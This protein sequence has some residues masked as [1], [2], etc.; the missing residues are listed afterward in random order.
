VLPARSFELNRQL[1]QLAGVTPDSSLYGLWYGLV[2]A[3]EGILILVV[4]LLAARLARFV[5]K[6]LAGDVRMDLQLV[7]LA[8]RLV[9][10]AVIALGVLGFLYV[11]APGMLTPVLGAVGLLGLAFGLAFQDVLKNFLSGV[12][13]L[14]ERPFRIGDVIQVGDLKGTVETIL[15]RVTVLK[16]AEGLQVL[17]PNQQVYTSAIVNST[18]YP[19]R[20]YTASARVAD[21]QLA[22]RLVDKVA[23]R[24]AEVKGVAEDPPPDVS[25]VPH[26]EWGATLEARFWVDYRSHDPARV[27]REVNAVLVDLAAPKSR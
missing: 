10:L 11:V 8:G 26:L 20:Q 2:T 13:L 14:L 19:Q 23:A 18:G 9:Y 24:L 21:A 6:A 1:L 3:G 5:A 12:F 27:Q 4:T 25:V 16:T 22:A 7:L 15:L 17:L